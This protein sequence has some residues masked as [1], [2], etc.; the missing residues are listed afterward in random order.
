MAKGKLKSGFGTDVEKE[1]LKVFEKKAET[2]GFSDKL[3]SVL[4]KSTDGREV[5]EQGTFD[6]VSTVYVL[7]HIHAHEIQTTLDNLCAAVKS[8]GWLVVAEFDNIAEQH[9]GHGEDDKFVSEGGH[10]H[11]S[12]SVEDI[13]TAMIRNGLTVEHVTKNTLDLWGSQTTANLLLGK[14]M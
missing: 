2:E 5:P 9:E 8:G 3:T 12:I 13:S 11:T 7:G 10:A 4:L 14:R 6:I 1:M